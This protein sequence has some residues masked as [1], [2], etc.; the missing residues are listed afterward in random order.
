MLAIYCK[1]LYNFIKYNKFSVVKPNKD[2]LYY[3]YKALTI[4][5]TIK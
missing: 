1:K 4:K 3:I 5:P 2:L